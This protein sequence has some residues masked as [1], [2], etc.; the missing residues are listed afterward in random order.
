MWLEKS[1]SI[2]V[3]KIDITVFCFRNF[4]GV[5]QGEN[6]NPVMLYIDSEILFFGGGGEVA[7]PGRKRTCAHKYTL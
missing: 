1:V 7:I 5:S 3:H 6:L 4:H 2:H